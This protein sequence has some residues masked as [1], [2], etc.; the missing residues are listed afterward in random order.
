MKHMQNAIIRMIMV[1]LLGVPVIGFANESGDQFSKPEKTWVGKSGHTWHI[2]TDDAKRLL[3]FKRLGSTGLGVEFLYDEA[4]TRPI[5]A[6]LDGR[7]W[8]HK[9][10][11]LLNRS[12]SRDNCSSNKLSNGILPAVFKPSITHALTSNGNARMSLGAPAFTKASVGD[13]GDAYQQQTLQTYIDLQLITDD[14]YSAVWDWDPF[15][16]TP[17]RREQCIS[18]C[19]DITDAAWLVC[20]AI[21]VLGPY[22]AAVG[23]ACAAYFYSRREDCR[24]QCRRL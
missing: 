21:G 3:S 14:W 5:A 22:G 23:F 16:A 2:R 7:Q 15:A 11:S 18:A 13:G 1:L 8:H 19:N 9:Q 17:E 12:D 4:S 20:G 24:A 6:R 10:T